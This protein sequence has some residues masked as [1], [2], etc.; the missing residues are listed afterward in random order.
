M[1]NNRGW[2][3]ILEATIAVMLVGGV[4]V[5][6]YTQ[7]VDRGITSADYFYSLERQILVDVASRSDLRLNVLKLSENPPDGNYNNLNKFINDSIPEAFG[8]TFRV[9]ELGSVDDFCKMSND[10]YIATRDRD[11]FVEEIVISS[12]LGAG[13]NEQIYKPKKLRLFV[14]EVR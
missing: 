8:Y 2:I 10:D 5:V 9:C 3:R 1:R 6:V 11:V 7:G 13:G 12:D 4:M 14:W